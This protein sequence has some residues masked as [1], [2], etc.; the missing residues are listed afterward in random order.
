MQKAFVVSRRLIEEAVL[1]PSCLFFPSLAAAAA[2]AS[3]T[4]MK[5]QNYLEGSS[6]EK[7]SHRRH[8]GRGNGGRRPPRERRSP[9]KKGHNIEVQHLQSGRR[10]GSLC[11]YKIVTEAC[12]CFRSWKKMDCAR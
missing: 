11:A 3:L 4:E 1:L 2:A 8:R 12:C 10:D 5:G 6:E 7:E 9:D